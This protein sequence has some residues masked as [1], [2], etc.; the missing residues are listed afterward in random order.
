MEPEKHC[1]HCHHELSAEQVLLEE[2]IEKQL[3]V[4]T[5]QLMDGHKRVIQSMNRL[6]QAVEK[7]DSVANSVAMKN[8]KLQ[9]FCMFGIANQNPELLPK[10]K[11]I[12]DTFFKN[13]C[14]ETSKVPPSLIKNENSEPT[15]LGLCI[16]Q[17]SSILSENVMPNISAPTNP[18]KL[19]AR[20]LN[21]S[22]AAFVFSQ[23]QENQRE[24]IV[25]KTD[26]PEKIQTMIENSSPA[27]KKL[28]DGN[29]MSSYKLRPD[30]EEY[31]KL[32]KTVAYK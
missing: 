19:D 1:H 18:V 3:S 5:S 29:Y 22:V 8:I 16:S 12:L 17:Y 15:F 2:Q 13:L 9:L 11:P 27:E 20:I 26:E 25:N 30:F 7:K 32:Q 28:E 21:N 23:F 4:I 10:L 6:I 31:M 14:D 24:E